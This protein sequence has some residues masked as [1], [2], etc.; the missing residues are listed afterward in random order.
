LGFERADFTLA[1]RVN[2]DGGLRVAEA[3]ANFLQEKLLVLRNEP[4]FRQRDGKG[5]AGRVV[6]EPWRDSAQ[7]ALVGKDVTDA[8]VGLLAD[9][10]AGEHGAQACVA[11]G[12]VARLEKLLTADERC[13]GIPELNLVSEQGDL[14]LRV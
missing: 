10:N 4:Q 11:N 3:R 5:V 13:A 2:E 14:A 6:G 9:A 8:G 12:L 7:G 1:E